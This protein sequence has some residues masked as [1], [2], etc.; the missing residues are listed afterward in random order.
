MMVVLLSHNS[1][2]MGDAEILYI[3]ESWMSIFFH[4]FAKISDN[5]HKKHLRI[6]WQTCYDMLQYVSLGPRGQAVKTSPFHGG[7]MG[8]IPVGVTKQVKGE[9][10]SGRRRIRL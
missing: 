7:I 10:V 9:P 4:A 5:E 8:S 6:A 2:R 1:I 3:K